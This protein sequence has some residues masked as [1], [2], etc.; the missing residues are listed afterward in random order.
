MKF[1]DYINESKTTIYHGDNFGTKK[2]EPK[3]MNNGNNQEGIGIYFGD[4]ETAETYGSNIVTAEIDPKNYIDSRKDIGK[5]VK[6]NKITDILNDMIKAD[7]DAMYYMITDW[8]IEIAEPEDIE[9]GHLEFL[10]DK[11]Q[12]DEVRNFQVTLAETFGV[13]AFVESWNKH[14]PKIHGTFQ[15][16]NRDIWYC[17]INTKVKVK[18]YN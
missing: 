6:V 8:G 10:A 7:A 2:L 15:P 13:Q 18:S 3:L 9:Y 5:Y 11:M 1:S 17:V 4:L 12:N 14:L 16:Q